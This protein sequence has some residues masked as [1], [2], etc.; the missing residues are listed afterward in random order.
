MTP[1]G[2]DDPLGDNASPIF[3]STTQRSIVPDLLILKQVLRNKDQYGQLAE[4]HSL[5]TTPQ[6]SRT[7]GQSGNTALHRM[8]SNRT[9]KTKPVRSSFFER[10]AYG[11]GIHSQLEAR[12]L[13]I[14]MR[15]R[16]RERGRERRRGRE[17]ERGRR[18][19]G[20]RSSL[21]VERAV[22]FSSPSRAQT[23][24]VELDQA[25]QNFPQ[26]C[27]EPIKTRTSRLEPIFS[28]F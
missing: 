10:I 23:L 13:E 3:N 27:F 22:F 24:S 12:K 11:V 16:W 19:E 18:S 26:A 25:S 2:V 17:G 9:E 1:R 4:T 6:T 21:E 20:G 5:V 15:W 14:D 7:L 28:F 8:G